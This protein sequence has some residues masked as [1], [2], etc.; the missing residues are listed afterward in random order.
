MTDRLKG[1]TVVFEQDM[2]DDDA[3]SL[4]NAI[5]MIKG[6]LKVAPTLRTHEDFHAETRIRAELGKKLFDVIYPKDK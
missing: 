6:V 4:L 1:C 3:E 5:G 2:R